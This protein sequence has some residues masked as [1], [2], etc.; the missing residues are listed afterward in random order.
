MP[1]EKDAMGNFDLETK[2]LADIDRMYKAITGP[3]FK[4]FF[5]TDFVKDKKQKC[6]I[7]TQHWKLQDS[8]NG[9]KGRY[10]DILSYSMGM[11]YDQ[12][13]LYDGQIFVL[14]LP[15][16]TF[17]NMFAKAAFIR[18]WVMVHKEVEKTGKFPLY[19][20]EFV[21]HDTKNYEL[22]YCAQVEYEGEQDVEDKPKHV[23]NT[24]RVYYEQ[25]R[26]RS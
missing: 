16:I 1:I 13:V 5:P 17:E 4:P 22:K 9:I 23:W 10:L 6:I 26:V 12:R 3:T 21:K 11:V 18:F 19:L 24:I 2:A 8:P 7:D 25:R 15:A 20:I 14:R